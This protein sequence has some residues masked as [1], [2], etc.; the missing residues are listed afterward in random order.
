MATEKANADDALLLALACG[1][2][3]EAAAAKAGVSRRTVFRRLGDDDFRRR[4]RGARQ[5][6]VERASGMLTAASMEAVKTLLSLMDGQ[7]PHASRL[8][9]AKSILELGVRLRDLTE[10][11]QRLAAL[12]GEVLQDQ[13]TKTKRLR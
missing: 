13:D 11:E 10:I 3:A 5:E 12:E 1:A 6:M 2:T 4:L 9:A 7:A 8:G